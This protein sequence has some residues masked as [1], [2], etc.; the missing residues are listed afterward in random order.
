MQ[1]TADKRGQQGI[2]HTE[3]T[4]G[5]PRRETVETNARVRWGGGQVTSGGWVWAGAFCFF[6]V[7]HE[8]ALSQRE[9]EGFRVNRSSFVGFGTGFK[10]YLLV[11]CMREILLLYYAC[12]LSLLACSV[13]GWFC[14]LLK[15]PAVSVFLR[16]I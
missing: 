13:R 9:R 7:F 12:R 14:G 16:S 4:S 10:N 11:V 2:T 15:G 8:E 6:C 1:I 3:L 5:E